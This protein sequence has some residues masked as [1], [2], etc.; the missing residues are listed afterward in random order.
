MPPSR[1]GRELRS[2]ASSDVGSG[3][4]SC[5]SGVCGN[6]T[7]AYR[8]APNMNRNG[9]TTRSETA[10]LE[11]TAD[12]GL[13]CMASPPVRSRLLNDRLDLP[14]LVATVERA[15]DVRDALEATTVSAEL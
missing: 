9:M 12:S 7:I 11:R 8:P 14:N 1:G 5:G 4:S 6:P 2:N 15:V 3:I 10:P 13:A